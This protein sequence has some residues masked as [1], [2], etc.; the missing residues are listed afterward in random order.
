MAAPRFSC[1]FECCAHTPEVDCAGGHVRRASAGGG[2]RLHLHARVFVRGPPGDPSAVCCWAGLSL[3]RLPSWPCDQEHI[4]GSAVSTWGGRRMRG[5]KPGIHLGN[6]PVSRAGQKQL[7]MDSHVAEV[8]CH[9]LGPLVPQSQE[10][11]DN[12][13]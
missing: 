5:A 2:G 4:W 8:E 10:K 11:V 12:C 13:L 1:A 6:S 7:S 9:V 3:Q